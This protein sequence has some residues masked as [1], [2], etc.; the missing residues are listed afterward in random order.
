MESG[1]CICLIFYDSN[2]PKESFL[3]PGSCENS[4]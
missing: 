2:V 1:V 3:T 4:K